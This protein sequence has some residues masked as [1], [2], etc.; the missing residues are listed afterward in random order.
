MFLEDRRRQFG[1]GGDGDSETVDDL[2]N[3]RAVG[4][5]TVGNGSEI[6]SQSFDT[7]SNIRGLG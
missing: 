5:Q 2:C 6:R 7:L 1:C 3:T 4:A